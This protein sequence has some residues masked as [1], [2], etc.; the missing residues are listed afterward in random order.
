MKRE[1]MKHGKGL[2]KD[3]EEY[4]MGMLEICQ[5]FHAP[6][7]AVVVIP[8]NDGNIDYDNM[9][10]SAQSHT[11]KLKDDRVRKHMLIANGFEAVK[12]PDDRDSAS[13]D[14]LPESVKNRAMSIYSL[15]PEQI[16]EVRVR[17][18]RLI[19]FAERNKTSAF[20]TV[21]SANS[22]EGTEYISMRT[23]EKSQQ[24]VKN[25]HISKHILVEDKNFDVVPIRDAV[26]FDM[27]EVFGNV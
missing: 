19:D 24:M 11:A 6:M 8:D 4:L 17:M 23:V 14:K 1:K 10:Y 25:N 2:R 21:A 20:A 5:I 16:A 27:E 7:F 26:V 12:T 15:K 9:V 18:Q 3:A 13:E 22:E